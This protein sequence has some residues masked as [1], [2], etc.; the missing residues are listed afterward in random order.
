MEQLL[1]QVDVKSLAVNLMTRIADY[2]R[3]TVAERRSSAV[4]V[5]ADGSAAAPLIPTEVDAFNRLR[6]FCDK[7]VKVCDILNTL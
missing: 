5:A 6:T 4:A 3:N 7:I 1:P 2:A